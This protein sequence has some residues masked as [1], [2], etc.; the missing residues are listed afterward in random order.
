[1]YDCKTGAAHSYSVPDAQK[2]SFNLLL[3]SEDLM[4]LGKAEEGAADDII[5]YI[6]LSDAQLESFSLLSL[7]GM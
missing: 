2:K 3:V 4:M 1:M 5:R 7:T 6:M